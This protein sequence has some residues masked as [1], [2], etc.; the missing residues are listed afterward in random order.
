M[1]PN[2]C[3]HA[4]SESQAAPRNRAPDAKE[5]LCSLKEGFDRGHKIRVA[6]RRSREKARG[7]E[8]RRDIIKNGV[9]HIGRLVPSCVER[10]LPVRQLCY[11]EHI[12][13]AGPATLGL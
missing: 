9:P 6:P 1:N 2:T 4:R 11:G 12:R 3:L 7:Q 10:K 5:P 8:E 13:E